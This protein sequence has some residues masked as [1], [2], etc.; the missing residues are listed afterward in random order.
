[1]A[2]N[3]G[4]R[5]RGLL[6]DGRS[7]LA[8]GRNREATDVFG[9]VLLLEPGHAGARQ[10]QDNAR[11]AA[12]EQERVSEA[13][14]EEAARA[15]DRGEAQQARSLLETVLEAGGDRDRALTLLDRLD[16]RTGFIAA[17]STA[18]PRATESAGVPPSPS[19]PWSRR[20]LVGAWALAFG[21]L[22]AGVA[23]SFER[24]VDHLASAPTPSSILAEPPAPLALGPG[25]R[26]VSQARQLLEEGD[27]A[28]ALEVL[29]RIA[30]Q[31]PAYP[32]ARQLRSK[33]QAALAR[34][35]GQR[36]GP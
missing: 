28:G 2:L 23:A 17:G 13:R 12:A 24:L 4:D 25:D 33:A 22:A 11:A 34:G 10:G 16:H 27:A 31:E 21:L 1:L 14:L 32:F 6:E 9:R 30:P 15:A 8:A 26:A 35:G 5:I 20:A 36:Q 18:E 7:L 29:D 3:E 19:S